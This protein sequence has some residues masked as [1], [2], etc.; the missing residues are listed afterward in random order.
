M[1]EKTIYIKNIG[2]IRLVKSNKARYLNITIKPFEGVKVSVPRALSFAKAEKMVLKRHDWIIRHLSNMQMAESRHTVFDIDTKFETRKHS[3]V[4]QPKNTDKINIII[5]NGKINFFYPQNMALK[6][7]T[8]QSAIKIGIEHAWRIEAKEYLP[9]RVEKLAKLCNFNYKQ[10]KVRN[11]KTRWGSCS[12]DNNI[13]L[14][15]HLMRLPDELID[16][17]VLHELSH[18]I[19]KN[20]SHKF[21]SFLDNITGNA[22]GLEK[23]LKEYKIQIY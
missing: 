19:H 20:H 14:S 9:V 15:L 18:T 22:K 3:L 11:A 5:K 13:M 2:D 6:N 17:V 16:Y 21:W 8:V 7:K 4:I 10:V 12:K 1:K 23:R